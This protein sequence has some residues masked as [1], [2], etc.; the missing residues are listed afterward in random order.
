MGSLIFYRYPQSFV[1][2]AVT[3]QAYVIGYRLLFLGTWTSLLVVGFYAHRSLE[4]KS[5][6]KHDTTTPCFRSGHKTDSLI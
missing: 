2:L 6:Y 4:R 3:G 5:G 1:L